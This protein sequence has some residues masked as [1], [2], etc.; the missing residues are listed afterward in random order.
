[1]SLHLPVTL[2]NQELHGYAL[3]WLSPPEKQVP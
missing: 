3:K 1:M 2:D